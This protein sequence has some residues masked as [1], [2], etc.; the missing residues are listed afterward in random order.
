MKQ[1]QVKNKYGEWEDVKSIDYSEHEAWTATGCYR[2]GL[3]DFRLTDTPEQPER[4]EVEQEVLK[5]GECKHEVFDTNYKCGKCCV[6]FSVT[7]EGI[8]PGKSFKE[9]S[10]TM[11]QGSKEDLFKPKEIEPLNYFD[12]DEKNLRIL[13]SKLNEVIEALNKLQARNK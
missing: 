3:N 9:I 1:L 4:G 11:E 7:Q 10:E 8:K 13:Q 5:D 2:P 12:L 6:S